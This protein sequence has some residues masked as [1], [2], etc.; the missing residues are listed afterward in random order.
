[1]QFLLA[2]VEKIPLFMQGKKSTKILE[3]IYYSDLVKMNENFQTA[4][5]RFLL[6][7]YYW[8]RNIPMI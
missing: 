7:V 1:M 4:Y 3:I 6:L 5:Y 2:H 8:L